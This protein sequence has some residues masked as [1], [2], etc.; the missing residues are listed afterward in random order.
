MGVSWL[1]QPGGLSAVLVGAGAGNVGVTG[2]DAFLQTR[3]GGHHLKGGAGG[4]TPR[5]TVYL[6][7]T[8]VPLG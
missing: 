3:D 5:L 4:Y 8:A 6:R 2:D 7:M 1:L